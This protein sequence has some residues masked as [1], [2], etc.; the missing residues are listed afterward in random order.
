VGAIETTI[1][2]IKQ[3]LVEGQLRPGDRLPVEKD[4]AACRDGGVA[5]R[6]SQPPSTARMVP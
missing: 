2:K 4:F 3:M 6:E 5:Q 1:D